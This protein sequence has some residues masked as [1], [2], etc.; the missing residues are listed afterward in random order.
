MHCHSTR[1]DGRNTPDEVL[2]EARRL[3][4]D[5]LALTD[6][7]V[8]ASQDFQRKLRDSGIKTCDSVEISARNFDTGK[9]LHVVSYAKNFTASLRDVLDNTLHQKKEK[10]KGQIEKLR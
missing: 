10:N 2:A 7:D 4:L 8:I 5:F 3:N 6:H 1:S 9:S